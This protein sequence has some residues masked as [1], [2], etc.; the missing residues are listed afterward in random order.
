MSET[1][2]GCVQPRPGALGCERPDSFWKP[3][4]LPGR[5]WSSLGRKRIS[6]YGVIMV[7]PKQGGRRDDENTKL[8]LSF[9]SL[10]V[11]CIPHLNLMEREERQYPVCVVY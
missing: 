6:R 3:R 2:D 9:Y 11:V 5:V 8:G 1:G 7:L 10:S 4:K